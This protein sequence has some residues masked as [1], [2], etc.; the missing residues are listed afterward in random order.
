MP[1]KFFKL[2]YIH[3]LFYNQ[4]FKPSVTLKETKAQQL[5][6]QTCPLK[7]HVQQLTKQ[8]NI[9]RNSNGQ[10]TLKQ[11]RNFTPKRICWYRS[12]KW[13]GIHTKGIYLMMHQHW[14]MLQKSHAGCTGRFNIVLLNI[15]L[16]QST[17]ITSR[18]RKCSLHE[19]SNYSLRQPYLTQRTPAFLLGHPWDKQCPECFNFKGSGS[20]DVINIRLG[21]WEATGHNS[22][23]GRV[24]LQWRIHYKKYKLFA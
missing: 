12:L 6:I 20:T 24:S 8:H 9:L 10:H 21:N 15:H 17:R 14:L 18:R 13:H 23:T 5:I 19:V 1:T 2:F 16:H 22:L 7:L 11:G 3:K 4:H